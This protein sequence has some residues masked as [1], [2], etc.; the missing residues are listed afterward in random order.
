M[1]MGPILNKY[2]GD[3]EK[4]FRA[5]LDEI[6]SAE[7]CALLIDEA[8]KVL[9]TQEDHPVAGRILSSLLWWMQEHKTRVI[10]FMTTNGK[11]ILPPELIRPG[12]VDEELMFTGLTNK[13]Q[14]LEFASAVVDSLRD[15]V[16]LNKS[17]VHTYV[18]GRFMDM[19]PRATVQAGIGD[20]WH[21][22]QIQVTK[23]V[24]DLAK[25]TY[26]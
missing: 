6:D 18:E 7:P 11:D 23:A 20:E 9:R 4:N 16:K 24:F 26:A 12:R 15:A 13:K 21:M 2:V 25:A 17:Q 1:D 8:E 3:S 10:T 19:H 5:A 22:T 14:I